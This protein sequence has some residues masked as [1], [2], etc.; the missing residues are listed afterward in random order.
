MVYNG[1]FLVDDLGVPPFYQYIP[2][3]F[4]PGHQSDPNI[5]GLQ[6]TLGNPTG[7]PDKSCVSTLAKQHEL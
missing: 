2:K 4:Q 5:D 6:C 7:T 1:K 3:K